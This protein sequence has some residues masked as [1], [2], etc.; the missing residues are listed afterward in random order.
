MLRHLVNEVEVRHA[1]RQPILIGTRTVR[2]SEM[3][4]ERMQK[5]GL[6]C[7]VLNAAQDEEE[8]ELVARAGDVGGILIA[9]NMAGRGTHIPVA[10]EAVELGGLHVIGVE[11]NESIRIDRQLMGRGARQGQPGSFQFFLSTEDHLFES[12]SPAMGKYLR[13]GAGSREELGMQAVRVLRRIQ[14]GVEKT[15]YTQRLSLARRDQ[16]IDDTRSSLA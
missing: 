7:R 2:M 5:V 14:R 9:T 12:F 3:I 1:T 13:L 4:F 16:W 15:R 8:S 6:N 11:R 10:D